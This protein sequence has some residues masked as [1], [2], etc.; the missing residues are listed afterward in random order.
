MEKL[1]KFKLHFNRIAMQRGDRK[2]WSI[3]LSDRCLHAE[4]IVVDVPLKTV[5]KATAQQPRAFFVGEGRGYWVEDSKGK[6]LF[7]TNRTHIPLNRGMFNMT[8][9]EDAFR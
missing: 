2:V 9:K 8:G 3:R 4:H 6:Y 7:I 1:R 5:Y